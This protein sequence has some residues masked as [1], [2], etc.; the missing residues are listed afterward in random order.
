MNRPIQRAA[1]TK[2]LLKVAVACACLVQSVPG[3]SQGNQGNS[4][5]A[6]LAGFEEVHG[7]NLGI[8]AIFSTGSG[9]I[10]LLIDHNRREIRYELSYEFPNAGD[11]PIV[12]TQFVNQAH[13]HFGQHH[14]AGGITVWLCQS[15]DNPAPAAVA[16]NTPTCPSPSGTVSGTILPQDVLALAAQGLPGGEAGFDALLTALHRKAV[17]ANVH[18]DRFPPGEIRAQLGN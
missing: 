18:T 1:T 15:A 6:T 4:F 10:R 12:G 17:Y 2:R 3:V 9:Q 8:G 16:A 7:P 11:T 14:T 5:R 13:L